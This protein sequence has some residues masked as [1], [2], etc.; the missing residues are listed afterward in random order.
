MRRNVERRRRSGSREY[1]STK[2]ALLL[3]IINLNFA[4]R[5][6]KWKFSKA[7][8]ATDNATIAEK[9]MQRLHGWQQSGPFKVRIYQR[10]LNFFQYKDS[11]TPLTRVQYSEV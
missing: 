3:F 5:I 7:A 8:V 6:A 11:K 10:S 4:V 2:I 1:V 9:L